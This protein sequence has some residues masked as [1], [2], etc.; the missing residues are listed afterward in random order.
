MKKVLTGATY[1]EARFAGVLHETFVAY[2]GGLVPAGNVTIYGEGTIVTNKSTGELGLILD[3][4]SE[5]FPSL[6]QVHKDRLV[7]VVGGDG[8]LDSEETAIE[9]GPVEVTDYE[10]VN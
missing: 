8:W 10:V 3:D 6:P 5:Y 7:D 4:E 2:R 1:N 9:E